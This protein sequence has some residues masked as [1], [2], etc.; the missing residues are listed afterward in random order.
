MA[1][2]DVYRVDDDSLLLDLQA[3]Y[4]NDFGFRVVAP[5]VAVARAERMLPELHP[6]VTF[7]G[8]QYAIITHRLG[9]VP[10]RL[11]LKPIGSATDYHDDILRALDVLF[12][13]F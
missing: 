9:S 7:D 11:L 8:E 3:D 1:R 13:G 12:T 10:R 2:F 4:L 5:M 6:V